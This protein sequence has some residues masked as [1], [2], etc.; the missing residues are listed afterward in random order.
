MGKAQDVRETVEEELGRDR[1]LDAGGITVIDVNG[2]VALNGTVPSYPQYVQAAEA[3]GRVTGV[4]H[5]HN[6]LEVVLPPDNYRDD[7]MLT[8]AANNTLAASTAVPGGVEATAKNGNITLTGSV[9]YD[10]QREAA[11][12]AVSGLTG[13]RDVRDEIDL[14]FDVDAAEVNRLVNEAL[15]S[16]TEPADGSSV[17]AIASGNTVMLSGRVRTQAQRDAIVSA[18]WRGHAVMAVIDD[19]LQITD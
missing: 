18:A 13:V 9:E 3:A 17:V 12:S 7:A 6:H 8:T 15:H 14:V 1:L 10:S 5:V 11:E 16:Q 4:T 2:V 19:A